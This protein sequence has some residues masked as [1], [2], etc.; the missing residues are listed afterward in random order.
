MKRAAALHALSSDHHTGLVLARRARQA[1]DAGPE[2]Q[3]NGWR[4]VTRRFCAEL[5]PHFQT[6]EEG[7]FR[8]S[9]RRAR[10]PSS[11]AL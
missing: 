4:E 7:C 10:R 2:V 1:V 6:E 9:R 8:R 11:S 3:A 5:E